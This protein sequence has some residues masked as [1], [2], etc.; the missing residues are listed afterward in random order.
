MSRKELQMALQLKDDEYFRSA[1][2][3][4]A[5]RQGLIGMTIPDKPRSSKQKYRLTKKGESQTD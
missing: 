4:P 5:L 1:Y 2:I 3:L